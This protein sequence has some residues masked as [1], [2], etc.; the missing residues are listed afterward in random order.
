MNLTVQHDMDDR[1]RTSGGDGEREMRSVFYLVSST[2]FFSPLLFF[3]HSPPSPLF[4]SLPPPP[5]SPL[6]SL[7]LSALLTISRILLS[8]SHA[9]FLRVLV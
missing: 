6:S 2:F 1:E 8:L 4:I 5:F 9:H 7:L 3:S